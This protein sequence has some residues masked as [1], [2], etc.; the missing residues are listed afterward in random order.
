MLV[1]GVRE[2]KLLFLQRSETWMAVGIL[3][4]DRLTK[5]RTRMHARGVLQGGA[6][7][8]KDT[9]FLWEKGS[10]EPERKASETKRRRESVKRRERPA[11]G[12]FLSLES[13]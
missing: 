10:R 2:P 5:E 8:G 9:S 11:S 12:L 1:E 13:R 3:M 7:A 4:K 6:K